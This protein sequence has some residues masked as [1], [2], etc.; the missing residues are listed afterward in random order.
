MNATDSWVD[1]INFRKVLITPKSGFYGVT[2][3]LIIMIG[4]KPTFSNKNVQT[5]QNMINPHPPH[6]TLMLHVA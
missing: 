5:R 1:L 6:I 4:Y 2:H 3:Q